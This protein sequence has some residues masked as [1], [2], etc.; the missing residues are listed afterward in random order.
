VAAWLADRSQ[1]VAAVRQGST[2]T[3][4]SARSA[5]TGSTATT[6]PPTTMPSSTTTTTNPDGATGVLADPS[7]TRFLATRTGDVTAEVLDLRTGQLSQWRPGTAEDTASIVKVDILATLLHQLQVSGASLD[8]TQRWLCQTMIEESDNNSASALWDEVGQ[9]TG[10][11]KFNALL[12]LTDTTPGTDG[13]WGLTTTT[14]L[15]QVRLLE[16]IV[17]PNN[18]LSTASRDYELSLME[19]IDSGENWGVSFGA[20]AGTSV[21]LKNGWLPLQGWT[22]WQINS[23]G[24]VDG[25]G[26]DYLIAVLTQGNSTEDYGINTI[27]GLS[28]LVWTDLGSATATGAVTSG[29][30]G[31]LPGR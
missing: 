24:W 19:H 7:I 5:G 10:V 15:D 29:R 26:R 18:T 14:A 6:S 17:S 27:Q 23:I 16:S 4:N 31:G 3:T 8:S 30:S 13:E 9:N 25:G 21:A 1:P 28:A 11:A 20:T 2:L 22:D 12:G